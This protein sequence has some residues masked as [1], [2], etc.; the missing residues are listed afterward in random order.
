V[1]HIEEAF[2]FFFIEGWRVQRARI[3]GAISIRPEQ[4]ADVVPG[5]V[6]QLAGVEPFGADEITVPSLLAAGAAPVDLGLQ[7]GARVLYPSPSRIGVL[8]GGMAVE[9]DLVGV[10]PSARCAKIDI[11]IRACLL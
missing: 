11:Q 9:V 6:V 8:V 4:L 3:E 7:F 2:N 10:A 5:L 1:P